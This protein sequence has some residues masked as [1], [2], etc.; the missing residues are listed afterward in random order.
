MSIFLKLNLDN[1]HPIVYS[2]GY[3]DYCTKPSSTTPTKL[4]VIAGA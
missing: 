3:E 2:Y 4:G 1:R